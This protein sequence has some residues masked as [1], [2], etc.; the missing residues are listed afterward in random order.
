[1]AHQISFAGRSEGIDGARAAFC[2][3]MFGA[4]RT[5]VLLTAGGL[6]VGCGAAAVPP[7]RGHDLP[8]PANEPRATVELALDLPQSASCEEDF[9]LALYVHRGIE[10]IEWQGGDGCRARR[11]KVRYLPRLLSREQLLSKV[12]GAGAHAELILI[13]AAEARTR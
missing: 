2:A 8:V 3:P 4:L 12:R 6:L 5:V 11:A 7:P 9:D 10:L 13:P 1:M